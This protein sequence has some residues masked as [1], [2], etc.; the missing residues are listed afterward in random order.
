[1]TKRLKTVVAILLVVGMCGLGLHVALHW[2]G[3]TCGDQVCQ[4]C[5]AGHTAIPQ[6]VAQLLDQT[7]ASVQRFIAPDAPLF[8]FAPMRTHRIPRAP[9]A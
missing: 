4:A 6:P 9:P 2:H 3:D 8:A 1:M 7:A 5:H